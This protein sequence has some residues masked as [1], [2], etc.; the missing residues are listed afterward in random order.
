M[1]LLRNADSSSAADIDSK[2]HSLRC[3]LNGHAP[4][5]LSFEEELLERL[6]AAAGAEWVTDSAGAHFLRRK[7]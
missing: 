4:Q 1:N 2:E 3:V 5:A 6:L 7:T